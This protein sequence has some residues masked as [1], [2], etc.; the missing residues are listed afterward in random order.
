M[1]QPEEFF[2]YSPPE[3]SAPWLLVVFGG[4]CRPEVFPYTR[5][6]DA[7]NAFAVLRNE[8]AAHAQVSRFRRLS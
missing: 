4:G 8:N 1:A 7:R 5:E 2:L 3:E 6:I